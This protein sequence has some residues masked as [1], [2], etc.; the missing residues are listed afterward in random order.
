MLSCGDSKKRILIGFDELF[1]SNATFTVSEMTN[2][3]GI[4]PCIF[5]TTLCALYIQSNLPYVM[6][7]TLWSHKTGGCSR[8]VKP[9]QDYKTLASE[10][11]TFE[12]PNCFEAVLQF[13]SRHIS[14]PC[15]CKQNQRV[16]I[17]F[18]IFWSDKTLD[19]FENHIFCLFF[20]WDFVIILIR[21]SDNSGLYGRLSHKIDCRWIQV[22]FCKMY[23]ESCSGNEKGHTRQE[24]A[25]YR[26]SLRQVWLYLFLSFNSFCNWI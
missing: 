9:F 7:N 10:I 4:I 8:H 1:G 22:H 19:V 20:S 14:W 2:S 12:C 16:N 23:R 15:H 11:Q 13:N 5:N 26:W 17:V 6:I 3:N 24:F 25:E 21:K 18:V